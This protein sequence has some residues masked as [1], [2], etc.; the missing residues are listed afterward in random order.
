MSERASVK[1]EGSEESGRVYA[2]GEITET[3]KG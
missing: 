3:G 1:M 2:V